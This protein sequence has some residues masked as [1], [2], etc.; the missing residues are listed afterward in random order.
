MVRYVPR[1]DWLCHAILVLN[2][3]EAP[4]LGNN[5]TLIT[6]GDGKNIKHWLMN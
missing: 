4:F 5:V 2:E 1:A 6:Q 3:S